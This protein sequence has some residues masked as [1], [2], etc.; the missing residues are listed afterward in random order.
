MKTSIIVPVYNEENSII[1]ILNKINLQKKNIDLEIIIS[2]DNS[3]DSTKKLLLENRNLYDKIYFANENRGKG[4]AIINVLNIVE[5]DYILIQDA[6]LEYD[7]IDYIKLL[8]P[9]YKDKADVVYGSRFQGSGAKRV[10]YFTHRVANFFLTFFVNVLTNINFSDVE[11]GYKVIKTSLFKDLN[12]KEKSFAIEIELTMKLSKK[13]IRFYE[14]G[15][16]YYGRT[17]EE[18]K[19]IKFIDGLIALY[20]IFYYKLLN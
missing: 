18:G 11:T 5:G 9:I 20:K 2:D 14:V 8:D 1:K 10:L 12:I 6:D 3:T 7:P 17:Y 4:S 13:K 15:I 16:S 19:K